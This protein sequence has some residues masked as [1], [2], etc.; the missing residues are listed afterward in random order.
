MPLLNGDSVTAWP[1]LMLKPPAWALPRFDATSG[2][3]K[4]DGAPRQKFIKAKRSDES[5]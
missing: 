2:G 4:H 5:L 1:H 3:R